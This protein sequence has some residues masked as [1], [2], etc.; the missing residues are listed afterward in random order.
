MCLAMEQDCLLIQGILA[1]LREVSDISKSIKEDSG[2]SAPV[3]ASSS[4]LLFIGMLLWRGTQIS[5][6]L[7]RGVIF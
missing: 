2:S 6:T 5:A 1:N 4:A 3:L 7:K